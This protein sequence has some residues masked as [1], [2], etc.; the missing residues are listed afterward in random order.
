[1][2]PAPKDKSSAPTAD[3]R[4]EI[5]AA[6]RSLIA[7]RGFEGLRT[8]DIAGRVGINVATLHYHVPT[9]EALI[10]LVAQSL[11]DD[12]IAQ[13]NSRP[14][15]AM[16]PRQR[17]ISEFDDFRENL[18]VN[19]DLFKVM[20]E[21]QE[22]AKRDPVIADVIRPMQA[23]WFAQVAEILER[24]RHDGSFRADLDPE[25]AA[26]VVLGAMI[27]SQRH[28]KA[29]MALFDRVCAELLRSL[30]DPPSRVADSGRSRAAKSSTTP[31]SSPTKSPKKVS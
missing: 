20:A 16:T 22:R 18:T 25:A 19:A 4:C 1:M 28:P 11:R 2:K 6:A 24:G 5:A 14:R 9:K 31:K 21:L 7:E 15:D 12:F 27:A 30:E 26:L 3:R 10:A 13:H 17:L 8:R 23:F 29:S